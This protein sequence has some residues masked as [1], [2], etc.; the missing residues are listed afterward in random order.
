MAVAIGGKRGQTRS[1]ATHL[2]S[3]PRRADLPRVGPSYSV[4]SVTL[5]R[6]LYPPLGIMDASSFAMRLKMLVCALLLRDS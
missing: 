2:M 5:D 1:R 6:I 3:T 4:R